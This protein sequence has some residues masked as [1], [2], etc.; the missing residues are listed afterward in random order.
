M[1]P[2]SFS[3]G[4]RAAGAVAKVEALGAEAVAAAKAT[5]D[6]EAA[7]KA[8]LGTKAAAKA[9]LGMEAAAKGT[10]GMEAAVKATLDAG[11]AVGPSSCTAVAIATGTVA[12]SG[13]WGPLF[14][15]YDPCIR[16]VRFCP[17]CAREPVNICY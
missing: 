6:R 13:G 2:T 4:E 12:K 9:T 1:T 17:G 8:T 7:A 3:W 15:T 16:W 5:L 14:Y 11:A 10:L